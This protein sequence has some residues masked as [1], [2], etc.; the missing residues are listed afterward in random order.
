[1]SS[2]TDVIAAVGGAAGGAAKAQ[3]FYSAE[4]LKRQLE[5]QRDEVRA[6]IAHIAQDGQTGRATQAEA[7]RNARASEAEEGRNTRAADVEEGRNTRQIEREE[8]R[9]TRQQNQI[10]FGLQKFWPDLKF[11]YDALNTR[12]ATTRAGQELGLAGRKYVA[13]TAA[14]ESRYRTD[15]TVRHAEMLAEQRRRA[16]SLKA[17]NGLFG[18]G[19]ESMPQEGDIELPP[20]V[21]PGAALATPSGRGAMPRAPL[22]VAPKGALPVAPKDGAV[23]AAPEPVSLGRDRASVLARKQQ[24]DDRATALRADFPNE[25]DYKNL[26]VGAIPPAA[27]PQS[28]TGGQDENG[29]V[30][31]AG[32]EETFRALAGR[33]N[34]IAASPGLRV[35]STVRLK[36]GRRLSVTKINSDGTFE[37]VDVPAASPA[38]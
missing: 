20:D 9:N 5:N 4:D 6:L 21:P 10:N 36:N 8:G 19:P 18:P 38:P 24:H 11:R 25:P 34:S 29:M 31:G 30:P 17:L 1:M 35:G 15:A 7:G 22:P 33:Q 2:W 32:T 37:G 16:D 23:G 13:D 14:D 27:A 12:N 28:S 3:Q 26:P